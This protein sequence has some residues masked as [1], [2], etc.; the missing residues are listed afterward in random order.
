MGLAGGLIL[1]E[2]RHSRFPVLGLWLE[3]LAGASAFLVGAL[4]SRDM[5]GAIY[6]GA[7]ILELSLFALLFLKLKGTAQLLT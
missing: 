4:L 1:M 2:Q 3:A 7:P 5:D 6:L